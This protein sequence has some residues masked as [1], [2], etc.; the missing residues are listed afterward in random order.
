MD[1]WQET[2]TLTATKIPFRDFRNNIIASVPD[3]LYTKTPKLS[4]VY[5]SA[6]FIFFLINPPPRILSFNRITVVPPNLLSSVPQALQV[7]IGGCLLRSIPSGFLRGLV[8]LT[9][10]ALFQNLL[11]SLPEDLLVDNTK[12]FSATLN[13]NL[14]TTLPSGLFR[15]NR[16]LVIL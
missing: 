14:L 5:G 2:L 15:N 9:T 6:C 4:D 1:Q 13:T 8:N 10:L 16:Q 3:D 11:T 7:S 12:L